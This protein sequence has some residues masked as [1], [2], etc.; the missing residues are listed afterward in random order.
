MIARRDNTKIKIKSTNLAQRQIFVLSHVQ[1]VKRE[2]RQKAVK[3]NAR[4]AQ[5]A[6]IKI[7]LH[8]RATGVK[9][10]TQ[11]QAL[12]QI[13][14]SVK[15]VTVNIRTKTIVESNANFAPRDNILW[16]DLMHVSF[17]SLGDIKNLKLAK[18]LCA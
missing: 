2:R 15:F 18:M 14:R 7:K 17:V 6:S 13:R 9:V 16:T 11:G 5:L 12:Y 10:V 8:R 1:H 4:S 3:N